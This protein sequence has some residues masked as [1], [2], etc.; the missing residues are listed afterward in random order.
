[1][2][3]LVCQIDN[4]K[5][6]YYINN[7]IYYINGA[8]NNFIISYLLQFIFEIHSFIILFFKELYCYSI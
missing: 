4:E 7:Y 6:H 3:L 1:M 2:L 8:N 5:D